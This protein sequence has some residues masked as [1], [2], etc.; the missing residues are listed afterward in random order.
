[1]RNIYQ[2]YIK[3]ETLGHSFDQNVQ[4]HLAPVKKL[5]LIHFKKKIEILKNIFFKLK[6]IFALEEH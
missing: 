5:S 4:I 1:M 6:K 3:G 2:I